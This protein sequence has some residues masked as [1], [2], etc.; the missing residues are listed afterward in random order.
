MLNKK[1]III[2]PW[3]EGFGG[4]AEVLARGLA[5]ELN[6]R[7]VPTAVFTTCSLS[8]YDSW[9][10]DHHHPGVYDS[11][12]IEVH[13]Y[14]TTKASA[15]YQSVVGKIQRGEHITA[16]DEQDFCAYGINSA[17][18]TDSLGEYMDE[19][20]EF[21]ALPYF[22]GLTHA[23]INRYP[24]RISLVP[25]FHNEA[26]FYWRT[27]EL[28]LRNAK[29]IFY[30]SAEE[31][32]MTIEYYGPK[33]G[34]RIVES[35]VTGV[36]VEL[37]S[38]HHG[39]SVSEPLQEDYFVYVGRKDIGKNVH[40]LCQWFRNYSEKFNRTT[41]LVFVGGGDD[42]LVSGGNQFVNLGYI[43]DDLKRH[44]IRN[45]KAVI[46]LSEKESFSIAIMEGWLLGVPAIVSANCAVTRNH[47]RRCNG[48]LY[49]ANCDEFGMALRY[50][51]DNVAVRR[52]LAANGRRYVSGEFSFDVVLSRYLRELVQPIPSTPSSA[53]NSMVLPY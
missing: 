12:G 27:T 23:V 43:S 20:H 4:G 5:R 32:Q 18:L 42:S 14:A 46:N 41:K 50:L 13:R 38:N 47:V 34:R 7:G 22:H 49:V 1:I 40:L 6:R 16:G 45:A 15:Q 35:I 31:K 52:T 48:G 33:I 25:C 17:A 30:N 10:E 11:S 2:T 24:G 26:Q 44:F 29:H 19:A 36:G 39:D 37:P 21:I 51:S 8:P 28:L 9:W 53:E 3:Y